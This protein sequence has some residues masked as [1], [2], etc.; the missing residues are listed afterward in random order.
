MTSWTD[1][2]KAVFNDKI[3]V[4]GKNFAAIAAFVKTKVIHILG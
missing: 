4:Y 3:V 1:E 2:E